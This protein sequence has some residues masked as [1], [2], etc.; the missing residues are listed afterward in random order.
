MKF[1]LA[2]LLLAFAAYVS[3]DCDTLQRLKVKHQWSEAFGTAHD[4][5]AFGL[6]LWNSII[7]EHPEFRGVF[8]RVRGDNTYSC[9]FAAHAQRVLSGLDMTIS[10]LDEEDVLN[11]QLAHLKGQHAERNLKPEYFT[12]FINHLL[13]VLGEIHGTHLDFKAWHDC[14]E[15]ITDGI[16][17]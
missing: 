16:K 10:M 5:L 13:E 17:P 12:I 14:I 8:S 1:I 15:L 11:A 6:K 3:A 7:H 4:R 2:V 9:E